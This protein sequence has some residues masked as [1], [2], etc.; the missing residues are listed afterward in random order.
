M[1]GAFEVEAC[2]GTT[3]GRTIML[4]M[5]LIPYTAHA[6]CTLYHVYM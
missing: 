4:N 5:N 1:S 2:H 3:E 6:D